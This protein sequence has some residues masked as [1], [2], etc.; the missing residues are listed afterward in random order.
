MREI[1]LILDVVESRDSQIHASAVLRLRV[2][3]AM[4][5]TLKWLQ[6]KPAGDHSEGARGGEAKRRSRLIPHALCLDGCD[7][8]P[9]NECQMGSCGKRFIQRY[10]LPPPARVESPP[11]LR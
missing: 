1:G 5:A 10:S 7:Q 8:T 11:H 3:L 4:P 6:N 9:R 2:R